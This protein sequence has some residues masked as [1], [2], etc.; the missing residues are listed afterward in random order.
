MEMEGTGVMDRGWSDRDEGGERVKEGR[1]G[2]G[3]REMRVVSDV[4]ITGGGIGDAERFMLRGP[5]GLWRRVDFESIV[6]VE[7]SS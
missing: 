2:A 5:I 7:M 3:R 6:Q 1:E 4:V